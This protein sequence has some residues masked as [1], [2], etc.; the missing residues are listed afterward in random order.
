MLSGVI[1]NKSCCNLDNGNML[2]EVTVKI[3]LERIDTEKEVTVEVLLD[4]GVTEL[5][6]NSELARKQRFNLK[7]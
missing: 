3:G 2:R 4:S 5:V 1:D 7:K 6:M